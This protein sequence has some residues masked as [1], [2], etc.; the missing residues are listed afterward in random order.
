M[1]TSYVSSVVSGLGE[2]AA[3]RGDTTL[4]TRLLETSAEM[5]RSVGDPCATARALLGSALVTSRTE[6]ALAAEFL[7][8]ALTLQV[9]V[10]AI[11]GVAEGLEVSAWIF[12]DRGELLRAT[13]LLVA[14]QGLRDAA[15]AV[16]SV[17]RRER[18]EETFEAARVGLGDE[19]YAAAVA[20]GKTAT[21]EQAVRTALAES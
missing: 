17:W 13:K 8:E 3:E 19:R 4:A 1:P 10:G 5:S 9:E 11:L 7:A 6:P 16:R 20:E 18:C 21:W 14:A 2:L 12:G 15:G